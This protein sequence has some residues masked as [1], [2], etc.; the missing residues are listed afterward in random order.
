MTVALLA[1]YQLGSVHTV[2][3]RDPEFATVPA[4]PER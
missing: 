4:E 3:V 1:Q 2:V